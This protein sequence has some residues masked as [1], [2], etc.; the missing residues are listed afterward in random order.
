MLADYFEKID[1]IL[2][3]H[4]TAVIYLATDTH[5]GVLAF[6]D[7][8]GTRVKY[9]KDITR[10]SLDNLLA[11]AFARGQGATDGVGFIS[12]K[13]YELQH[14]ASANSPGGSVKMGWDVLTD[15]MC[16]CKCD[17]FVHTL[18]NLALAVSYINPDIEMVKAK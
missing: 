13:G 8:Y 12:G 17:W 11:W 16:L 15:V 10:T 4:K 18:S 6:V 1:A 3:E 2:E 9:D 5:F 14:E 7:R